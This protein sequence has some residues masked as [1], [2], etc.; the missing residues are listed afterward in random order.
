MIG[1]DLIRA[2]LTGGYPEMLDRARPDRRSAWA[3]SYIQAIVQR[4]VRE[5]AEIEK[6]DHVPRLLQVLAHH[7][8]Q[9]TNF[10]KIGGPVGLDDKT[11]RVY[12]GILEQLFLIKRVEPWFNN[13][14]SRLVENTQATF[15]GFRPIGGTTGCDYGTYHG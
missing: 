15:S 14:L 7:S 1:A 9:L 3:R 10:T 13:R 4:D 11:T 2:V 6:L 12:L 8:A 5:I